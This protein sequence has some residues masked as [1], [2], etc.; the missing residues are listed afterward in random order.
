[1]AAHAWARPAAG[2]TAQAERIIGVSNAIEHVRQVVER[3]VAPCEAR[4]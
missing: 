4:C 3:I 1:M 2:R